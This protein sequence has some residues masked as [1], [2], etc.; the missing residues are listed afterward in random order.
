MYKNNQ[1]KFD[2]TA[3]GELL[4]DFT[5]IDVSNQGNQLFEAN[6]GGAPSNVLSML[7]NL[8]KKTSF[9]GKVGKDKF[10]TMLQSTLESIGVNVNGL[11]FDKDIKTTLAFVHIDKD[12]EREFSFYRKPGADMMLTANEVREDIIRESRIFHFGSLSMTDSIVEMATKKAI[13]IA[14]KEDILI[15]FDPNLRE[16]LWESLE[17]ARE[18]MLFG[19]SQCDLLKISDYE[20]EFLTGENNLEKSISILKQNK[21]LKLICVTLGKKGSVAICGDFKVQVPGFIQKDTMDT[22][23]AGDTFWGYI[24]N[25]IL[26]HELEDLNDMLLTEMLKFANAAASII[27]TRYGALKVMP[28]RSEIEE[29]CLTRDELA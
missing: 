18:K 21:N 15:S 5:N 28:T 2:V 7:Q 25:Y 20:L 6:P 27:T 16:P 8:D 9:I 23:G 26:E 17:I 22:T 19:I 4:V 13:D 1:K 11:V 14:K 12:G 29:L 24:L 3:L 10:G